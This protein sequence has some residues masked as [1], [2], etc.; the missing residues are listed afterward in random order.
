M[1]CDNSNR[2]EKLLAYV[3][4]HVNGKYTLF[5]ESAKRT[6]SVFDSVYESD[7]GFDK[8]EEE[9]EEYKCISFKNIS[10]GILFE[11]NYRQM[12]SKVVC[13]GEIIC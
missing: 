2:F 9:Y 11:V 8:D 3:N 13:D 1:D 10:D 6:D 5:Y 12:P 4:S 7:N